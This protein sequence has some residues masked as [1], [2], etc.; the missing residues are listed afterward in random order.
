[1]SL[2]LRILLHF[3]ERFSNIRIKCETGVMLY[4]ISFEIKL[5]A[6]VYDRCNDM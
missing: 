5:Q 2:M 1:M 4:S 6:P 3:P